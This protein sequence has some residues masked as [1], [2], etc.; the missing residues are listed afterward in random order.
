MCIRDRCYGDRGQKRLRGQR[1]RGQYGDR[2]EPGCSVFASR[3]Y[4][5]LLECERDDE[6]RTARFVSQKQPECQSGH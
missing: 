3:Q 2:A 6:L 4:E 1:S 5:R